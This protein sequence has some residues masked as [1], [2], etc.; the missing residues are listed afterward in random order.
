MTSRSIHAS[1]FWSIT[2]DEVVVEVWKWLRNSAA[3]T[4]ITSRSIHAS[5]FWSITTD[6]VVVTTTIFLLEFEFAMS[7]PFH[8]APISTHRYRQLPALGFVLR[9]CCRLEPNL[10]Q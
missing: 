5:G 7:S 9:C 8:R 4:G 1:G 2:T 10:S 3:I 6:D